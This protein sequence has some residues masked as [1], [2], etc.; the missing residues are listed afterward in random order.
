MVLTALKLHM[1]TEESSRKFSPA[2]FNKTTMG[3]EKKKSSKK[4]EENANEPVKPQRNEW[5]AQIERLKRAIR[6]KEDWKEKVANPVI[7]KRY[8]EEAIAQG[9][10]RD[11][12]DAALLE[13]DFYEGSSSEYDFKKIAEDH[14]IRNFDGITHSLFT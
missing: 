6:K 12:I 10:S 3:K 8:I 1:R 14:M 7:R 11:E 5:V 9:A 2:V 13:L 4:S